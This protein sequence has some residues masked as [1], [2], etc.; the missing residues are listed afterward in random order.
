MVSH[1]VTQAECNLL[2]EINFKHCDK[3]YGESA[4]STHDLIVDKEHFEK[5][6][7]YLLDRIRESGGVVPDMTKAASAAGPSSA[8]VVAAAATADVKPQVYHHVSAVPNAIVRP[9]AA[10][11]T[12]GSELNAGLTYAKQQELKKQKQ[13]QL[14]MQKQLQHQRLVQQ[15]KDLHQQQRMKLQQQARLAVPPQQQQQQPLR[16]IQPAAPNQQQ[17]VTGWVQLNN[18]MV[19]YVFRPAAGDKFLPV[20][21]VCGAAQLLAHIQDRKVS[22]IRI[23]VTTHKSATRLSS[24]L[25]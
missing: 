9:V 4:F 21:I 10:P 8:P 11:S 6:F 17:P 25:L 5:F 1:Y 15:Q 24:T 2:N 14:R 18:T 23:T 3:E 22:L 12:N 16:H 7:H 20:E 13:Q 19:P